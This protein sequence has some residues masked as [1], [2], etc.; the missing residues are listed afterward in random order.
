MF[1]SSTTHE[2]E[3]KKGSN[4]RVSLAFNTFYKGKIGA[5]EDL[6]ELVL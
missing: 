1:P 2:V 5:N 6:T 3:I 4:T